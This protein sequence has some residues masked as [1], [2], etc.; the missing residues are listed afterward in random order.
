MTGQETKA[1]AVAAQRPVSLGHRDS[2]PG[3]TVNRQKGCVPVPLRVHDVRPSVRRTTARN[4]PMTPGWHRDPHG[5]RLLSHGH[6]V[7]GAC[8]EVNDLPRLARRAAQRVCRPPAVP[9]N[10]EKLQEAS[11]RGEANAG[12]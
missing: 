2:E 1:D 7:P 9:G 11:A 3:V 12:I 4:G 10:R 8:L 5:Q 6:T